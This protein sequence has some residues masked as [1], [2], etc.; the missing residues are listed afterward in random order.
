MSELYKHFA[1]PWQ[2][3]LD[4]S[5]DALISLYNHESYGTNLSPNNG[6]AKGKQM[7]NLQVTAWKEMLREGTLAKFELYAD[8][9]YPHWWLDSCL[10]DTYKDLTY[11]DL[12][13]LS[14]PSG[15]SRRNR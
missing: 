6:F 14:T 10:K 3:V 13:T 12:L 4:F 9:A 2:E 11:D 5:D 8:E 1:S 15:Y 7:L